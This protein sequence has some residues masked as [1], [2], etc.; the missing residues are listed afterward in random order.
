MHYDPVKD[1]FA[2][3]LRKYP[4]LRSL[5]YRLLDLLFL[6]AWYVHRELRE[7]RKNF[8]GKNIKILDAGS[9]YG[10]YSYFMI[11]KL[12][13]CSISA[14]DVKESWI[15][16]CQ[17]FFTAK[18]FTD[19]KFE[20]GDLL[21]IS[22]KEACDLIVCVDVMEH[23]V[24][25]V[26]VFQNYYNALKPGGYLL[27]NTPSIFGGSDAHSH[28]DESFI[29]EHARNGYSFEDLTGKLSPLG[30][31][32]YSSRYSYGFWGDLYWRLI[33]KFPIL[34]VNKLKAAI[35]FLPLYYLFTLPF[36][37]LFMLIDYKK[38]NIVGSGITYVA[39][40]P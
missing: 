31:K 39:Q 21:E 6:R 14:I 7:I 8:S 10:Q 32:P 23:I 26:K 34:M 11:R 12:T 36:G 19:I 37:L 24:E 16:D 40:K 22:V 20:V 5:F 4:S 28:D 13:P 33:I 29:G 38:R 35:L 15:E 25:D 9:G 18:N 2:D 30:F 1:I 3:V 17:R 27:I